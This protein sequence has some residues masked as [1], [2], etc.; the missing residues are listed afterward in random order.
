[1]SK[2]LADAL[3]GYW[4]N[5]IPKIGEEAADKK[6]Q[7]AKTVVFQIFYP[8]IGQPNTSRKAN[9]A[10]L[11]KIPLHEFLETYDAVILEDIEVLKAQGDKS[12]ATHQSVWK[13]FTAFLTDWPEYCSAPPSS[14]ALALIE[15]SLKFQRTAPPGKGVRWN[16]P[17][18]NPQRKH[19]IYAITES[20]LTPEWRQHFHGLE[21]FCGIIPP[22]EENRL[23][24]E[25]GRKQ[26][27]KGM[28]KV[29]FQNYKTY[30][31]GYIGWFTKYAT[32]PLTG[33]VFLL[34]EITPEL[35]YDPDWLNRYIKWHLEER[36]NSYTM[37]HHICH[38]VIKIA[39][40]DLKQPIGVKCVDAHP[41]IQVLMKIRSQYD[42]KKGRRVRSSIDAIEKRMLDHGEC[43]QVVAYLRV[44]ALHFEERYHDGLEKREVMEDAWMDYF[45]I[46]LLTYGGM[47]IREIYQMEYRGQRLYYDEADSCY[48]CK[49]FPAEHKT[50]GDRAYPL[51]PGSLQAQLT[52]DFTHFWR[53]IRPQWSHQFVFYQRGTPRKQFV[54]RGQPI[55]ERPSHIIRRIMFNASRELFGEENAKAMTP[56]D[57]RRSSATW[58]AHYGHIEDVTI[59]AQLHGHSV[60]ML[61]DLYAQVRSEE[62][63]KQATAAF[64]R[65]AS[66]EQFLRRQGTGQDLRVR[67]KRFID[68]ASPDMLTKLSTLI[69]QGLLA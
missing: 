39:Q 33:E 63:T 15:P 16:I 54:N 32:N 35:L 22:E 12:A 48:W 44:R 14:E 41:Q 10:L 1:M 53:N 60:D 24:R 58:F 6:A 67:L 27:K 52:A 68:A 38:M 40:W 23:H 4:Q 43:E 29:S 31:L 11:A 13:D 20:E 69:D 19:L 7:K 9:Q 64:N 45:L 25:R 28:R 49:L 34:D 46:S 62:Q 65:T 18:E 66:R 55:S 36:H 59:F 37:V 47:R 42:P 21:A 57:F 5:L 30:S 3:K 50:S 51:F 61:M 56:H 2:S 8:R 17:R 26:N